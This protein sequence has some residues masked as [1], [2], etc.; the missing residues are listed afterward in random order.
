MKYNEIVYSSV[1]GLLASYSQ[2][3]NDFLDSGEN[4]TL[5]DIVTS[6]DEM[7]AIVDAAIATPGADPFLNDVFSLFRFPQNSVEIEKIDP[8]YFKKTIAILTLATLLEN[9]QSLDLDKE[10]DFPVESFKLLSDTG[11]MLPFKSFGVAN[12][13]TPKDSMA[14]IEFRDETWHQQLGESKF[15]NQLLGC[16]LHVVSS[17]TSL[18]FNSAYILVRDD[19]DDVK[20][21]E[22]ALRLHAISQG[23]TIHIPIEST[24]NP[25]L[26]GTGLISPKN[27]YQQFNET[28]L[29][30]S[31]FNARSDI[32]NKFLSLY[33]VIE[34]FMHKVPLVDLGKNNNGKM[35]SI[36]DF[37]RLYNTVDVNET[38]AIKEIF[39]IFWD[40]N[41]G[42]I[43][44]S[45]VVENAIKSTKTLPGYVKEDMDLLLTK[46]EVFDTNGAT[47]LSNGCT[48]TKYSLLI[49]KVRCAIVHNSETELHISHFNLSK[50][51][52][53]LIDEIIM[54][55]LEGLV[56][57]VISDKTSRV[58]YSGPVLQLY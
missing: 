16:I 25:S 9:D 45:K 19:A 52:I 30:L 54:K 55:P 38:A 56:F 33:H 40:V 47:Q 31:E 39:K 35:F 20:A 37:K 29:I 26:N 42:P 21:V 53:Y 41:I 49:Y 36:R 32:L 46:L 34:G 13:S 3:I 18:I 43:A 11:P 14:Y 28:I 51:L 5:L 27:H 17:D 24:I 57:K 48:S 22:A 58:W 44:F 50:T 4:D 1:R 10:I 8:I 15:N 6:I 7:L 23:K 12:I 2:K